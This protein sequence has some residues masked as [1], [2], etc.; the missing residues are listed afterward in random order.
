M[1]VICQAPGTFLRMKA[2]EFRAEVARNPPLLRVLHGYTQATLI[3]RAQIIGCD[4]FHAVEARAARWLLEMDDRVPQAEFA[5][6]HEFLAL[7]LGVRRQTA[8]AVAS[9]LCRQ[10]WVNYRRGFIEIVDRAGLEGATCECYEVIRDEFAR[11]VGPPIPRARKAQ[12]A[13]ES[14]STA[15][16]SSLDQQP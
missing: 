9:H 1:E 16:R 12:I 15:V 2:A 8:S 11:R 7:M 4:R 13:V 6:T 10:G 14:P 3:I 5:M